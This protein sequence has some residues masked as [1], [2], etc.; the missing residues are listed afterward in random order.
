MRTRRTVALGLAMA[1][2]TG[3]MIQPALGAGGPQGA[4]AIS[5]TADKQA[6]KPFQ[7]YSVRAR[8]VQMGNIAAT[9]PLEVDGKFALASIDPAKYL[10][11]LLDPQGKVVCTEGPFD[12]TKQAQK[13]GVTIDCGNPAA[14]WLLAAAGAAGI[15]AGIVNNGSASPSR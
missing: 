2:A 13:T 4:G 11:E 1:F 15:T 3:M 5:G 8:N 14:W 6:K 12:L 10:V 9:T 7:N